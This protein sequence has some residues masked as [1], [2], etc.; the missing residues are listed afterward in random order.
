MNKLLLSAF[1][2]S[3]STLSFAQHDYF[4]LKKRNKT[5]QHFWKDSYI[6]FQLK[7]G[8]W[9]KGIITNI[10]KDSF[11]LKIERITYSMMGSDTVHFSGF[12][13]ALSDIYAM[14]GKGL[15]IDYING[16]FKVNKSAGHVHWYWVKSGWLFR[17]GAIGYTVLH[18]ANGIINDLSFSG[19]NLGI[20][21][22]V[23]I[24]GVVLHKIYKPI[25]RL[26]TKYHME[27]VSTSGA[28]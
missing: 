26:G 27:S 18:I 2:I 9:V 25:F 7:D 1:L 16:G 23:F 17:T 22:G 20:A 6:T 11:E 12:H 5:V 14:P 21:A 3:L 28:F 10:K 13:Y 8:Q 19:I 15:K 4:V 24:A